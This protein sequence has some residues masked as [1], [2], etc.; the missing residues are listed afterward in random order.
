MKNFDSIHSFSCPAEVAPEKWGTLKPIQ[1][2]YYNSIKW[3]KEYEANVKAGKEPSPADKNTRDQIITE[4][5]EKIRYYGENLISSK[6]P[7][8]KVPNDHRIDM[9][10][11]ILCAFM[12]NLLGYDALRAA[13]TTY[14]KPYFRQALSQYLYSFSQHLSQYDAHNVGV[15]KAARQEFERQG[16]HPDLKM[17]SEATGLSVKVVKNTMRIEG[18]SV[19][20]DVDDHL[21]SFKEE[22]TD[23]AKTL[24]QKELSRTL[25]DALMHSLKPSEREMLLFWLGDEGRKRTYKEVAACFN[26][27]V[28]TVKKVLGEACAKLACNPEVAMYSKKKAEPELDT[29]LQPA[30]GDDLFLSFTAFQMAYNNILSREVRAGVH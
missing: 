26:T 12:T 3:L 24:A 23:P 30:S 7:G 16:I 14:F 13:P 5:Y 25:N 17:I 11:A 9:T 29:A 4:L 22:E 28:K 8:Y 21:N 18:T 19:Q 1:K 6:L 15:C 20:V 10:N 27:T 2:L